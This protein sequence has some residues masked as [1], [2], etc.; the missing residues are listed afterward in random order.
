METFPRIRNEGKRT[1]KPVE[2]L[3]NDSQH[4]A[5]KSWPDIEFTPINA[6]RT[7]PSLGS[8]GQHSS[9]S[10]YMGISGE[11]GAPLVLHKPLFNFGH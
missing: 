7:N 8:S 5:R 2:T 4:G 6:T 11:K 10:P 3:E 1:R 9:G